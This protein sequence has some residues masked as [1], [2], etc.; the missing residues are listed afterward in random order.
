MS[1]MKLCLFIILATMVI[2]LGAKKL[3]S[4]ITQA[5]SRTADSPEGDMSP[6]FLTSVQSKNPGDLGAGKVLVASRELGDPNFAETVILLVHYDANGVIG[7]ILNRR[8]N[9]PISRV[10]AQIKAAKGRSD[11]VYLGGPVETPTVFALLQST[12]K[13]DEAEHVLGG[14]YWISAKTAMEKAIAS[15]PDPGHLHV[16]LGYAGWT[17]DQLRNEVGLGGW[18]I[19]QADQQTIFNPNPG[20]LW[21]QMIKKTELNMAGFPSRVGLQAPTTPGF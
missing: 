5:A 1:Q 9:I 16:Y 2:F 20:S 12:H 15:R 18:F 6:A 13:L 21:R 8:T 10:L 11:P 7:L 3:E 19:F 4:E 14:L 17:T